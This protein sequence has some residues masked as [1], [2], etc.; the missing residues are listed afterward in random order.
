MEKFEVRVSDDCS[1]PLSSFNYLCSLNLL[2][3]IYNS[4]QYSKQNFIYNFRY[5]IIN[6]I[7]III[8]KNLLHYKKYRIEYVG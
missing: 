7:N 8:E 1:I 3:T 2:Y 6:I 5:P 4:R